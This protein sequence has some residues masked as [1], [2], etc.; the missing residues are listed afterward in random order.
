MGLKNCQVMRVSPFWEVGILR[1]TEALIP[2]L[3]K[4]FIWLFIY[5]LYNI[6]SNKLVV[7]KRFS[8]SSLRHSSKFIK[9]QE[10]IWEPLINSQWVI[11]MR[12]LGLIIGTWRSS[13]AEPLICMVCLW[14]WA[15]S[16]ST[17]LTCRTPRW[18]MQ[19]IREL[20][21]VKNPHICCQNCRYKQIYW[22]KVYWL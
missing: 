10:G 11:K 6:L 17:E 7:R 15:H 5:S 2:G 21:G 1:W 16:I 20:L 3:F 9:A 4:T 14:L 19:R 13:W 12:N 22:P 18:C 8:P